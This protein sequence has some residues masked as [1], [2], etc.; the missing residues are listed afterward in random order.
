MRHNWI[1]MTLLSALV[2]LTTGCGTKSSMDEETLQAL[3]EEYGEPTV[4]ELSEPGTLEEHLGDVADDSKKV[5]LRISGPLNGTDIIFLNSYKFNVT[6]CLDLLDAVI[7]AGGEPYE[8]RFGIFDD[9]TPVVTEDNVVG[10]RMF[11]GLN[12]LQ[13]IFLPTTIVRID[14]DAFEY[15]DHLSYVRLPE[16]LKIIGDEAFYGCALTEVELPDG[17]D[18][19]GRNV[20]SKGVKSIRIPQSVRHMS[21]TTGEYQDIYMEWTPNEI[22]AF[23]DYDVQWTETG[24]RS[25]GHFTITF[26]R[27]RLHVP[28]QYIEA[29]KETFKGYTGVV[30]DN[31][32][33]DSGVRG[34]LDTSLFGR[35]NNQNDPQVSMVLSRELAEAD[36]IDGV[37]YLDASN[38][39]YETEFRLKFKTHQPEGN[40]ILIT[41]DKLEMEYTGDPDD[42]DSDVEVVE[43]VTGQG[44]LTIIPQGDD[45]VKI[46]SSEARINGAVLFRMQ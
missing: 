7:V 43:H 9:G 2:L 17:L 32:D 11:S 4:V 35:W 29:Y 30:A 41:Y 34:V 36:G 12:N 13:K 39:Y 42:Y 26:R 33:E 18:S 5:F 22:K 19:L 44:E 8:K 38:E 28:E 6:L 14:D 16:S 31:G 25:Q 27:P 45:K 20:F 46:K 37:G 40:N 23:K 15:V 24:S 1:L 3:I 21:E 10:Y